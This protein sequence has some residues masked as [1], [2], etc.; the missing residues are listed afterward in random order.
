MIEVDGVSKV[1]RAVEREPGLSGALR[2]LWN[3]K[4]REVAA[5][6]DLR[7]EV[8][9]GEAVGLLG[10]NGA[11]KTTTLKMLT[12]LLHPTTGRL[13]VAGHRPQDRE[14]AFL[15]S[16]AL[17]MGQKQQLISDLPATDTFL[18]HRALYDLDRAT[19]RATVDELV[20]ALG[21]G[22][23]VSR[24]VRT[25]SLGQRMR[26]ELAVA[27]LHRPS[28][29]FLDEPTVGL[30]V[31]VT[32]A[33]RAFLARYRERT[34]A[35][36][37][38]TSHD[39]GDVGALV[40]RILLVD[41]GRLRFDGPIDGFRGRFGSGRRL[42]VRGVDLALGDLGFAMEGAQRWVTTVPV[43]EANGLL[44]RVLQRHPSADLTVHDPPLD[45][46]LAAAFGEGRRA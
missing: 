32:V 24:P 14:V 40:D 37:V 9:A 8:A 26:C 25:L 22:E 16:I 11:G 35:T 42:V 4:T 46:V 28:V 43:A 34:G 29:L 17:V 3:R 38:L 31:E 30:D 18:L 23:E 13:R 7:F 44:A 10:P 5:V 39:M 33:L 36:L 1:Y 6:T 2:S 41:R 45:E 15:G 19:W 12:G 20:E 27:L 21:I